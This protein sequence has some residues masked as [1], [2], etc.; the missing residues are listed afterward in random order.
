MASNHPENIDNKMQSSRP[1]IN[2]LALSQDSSTHTSNAYAATAPKMGGGSLR[3]ANSTVPVTSSNNTSKCDNPLRW[4]MSPEKLLELP[5]L[6][7]NFSTEDDRHYRQQA[8]NMIQDLSKILSLLPL[9][10]NTAIVYMHRFF[11]FH[12]FHLFDRF[13]IGACCI[14][15]ACKVEEQPRK[16]EHV[17]KTYCMCI[18]ADPNAMRGEEHRKRI[19]DFIMHEQ[20]LVETLGFDARVEHPHSSVIKITEKIKASKDLAQTSY[21]LATNTLHLTTF[22]LLYPPV[23]IACVCINLACKWGHWMIPKS[24]EKKDWW[25]YFA[26]PDFTQDKLD[27]LTDE[28]VT[29]IDQSPAKMKDHLKRKCLVTTKREPS[30]GQ[31]PSKES[32]SIAPG[33][34]RSSC[35]VSPSKSAKVTS[36]TGQPSSTGKAYPNGDTPKC[37]KMESQSEYMKNEVQSANFHEDSTDGP[38]SQ[39]L[40]ISNLSENKGLNDS[41]VVSSENRKKQLSLSQYKERLTSQKRASE[42]A[43]TVKTEAADNACESNYTQRKSELSLKSQLDT[44]KKENKLDDTISPGT[45]AIAN[46]LKTSLARSESKLTVQTDGLSSLTK[47]ADDLIS[48]GAESIAKLIKSSVENSREN[49]PAKVNIK[50]LSKLS[51]IIKDEP[52]DGNMDA[53]DSSQTN[54]AEG[55]GITQETSDSLAINNLLR[56]ANTTEMATNGSNYSILSNEDLKSSQ[57]H[58]KK[59]KKHK[60]DKS[61]KHEKKEKHAKSERKR[62]REEIQEMNPDEAILEESAPLPKIKLKCRS[63]PSQEMSQTPPPPPPI[64]APPPA[65]IMPPTP[66]APNP[67]PEPTAPPVIIKPPQQPENC[68]RP[69][70]L[71]GSLGSLLESKR[72]EM[73]SE[74]DLSTRKIKHKDKKKKDKYKKKEREG[75]ID[76]D[77]EESNAG[78]GKRHKYKKKHKSRHC[79]ATLEQPVAQ[80]A[81]TGELKLKITLG[82]GGS[83]N[84][85]KS[86]FHNTS[87]LNPTSTESNCATFKRE[88]SDESLH[89][90][91]S[92]YY[93]DAPSAKR[94][95]S[96]VSDLPMPPPPPSTHS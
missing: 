35:A 49:S 82:G 85:F 31:N 61:S 91:S 66:P 45:N 73:S 1:A 3:K 6:S 65:Q 89:D 56:A 9:V 71:P 20:L 57:K 68:I 29:I 12:S 7:E 38:Q 17:I 93:G 72:A 39:Q 96:L 28:L 10:T 90:S 46:M 32:T 76:G 52:S 50:P 95:K 36:S 58:K 25:Q 40:K 84:S 34:K 83:S 62:H 60:K 21:L 24:N 86:Q 55:T 11:M 27:T 92:H 4:I 67:E 16:L 44:P 81:Q 8:A 5:S 64:E 14:F 26:P 42:P 63:P 87:N 59:D 23:V 43:A 75:M 15:L 33:S 22:C 41:P 77:Y 37:I 47:K 78:T 51:D 79:D 48:P 54:L 13:L 69:I 88:R 18:K 30:S 2:A 80:I 70:S 74:D 94:V 19:Q 53:N